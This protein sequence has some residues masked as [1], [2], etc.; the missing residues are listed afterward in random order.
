MRNPEQAENNVDLGWL[1]RSPKFLTL[2]QF[3]PMKSLLSHGKLA[4]QLPL[5]FLRL[6]IF[7]SWQS[8]L[9][10]AKRKS[11]QELADKLQQLNIQAT[12]FSG[13]MKGLLEY[14]IDRDLIPVELL[15]SSI[16]T[17]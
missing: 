13:G 16:F 2:A 1:C 10:Q 12:H 5:S 3:Q 17:D 11:P 4:R 14:A 7:S 15:P 9:V 8:V 6:S